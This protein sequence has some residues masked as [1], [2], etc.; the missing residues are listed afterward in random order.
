MFIKILI[1]V[2][3]TIF[4]SQKS[5]ALSIKLLRE[6]GCTSKNYRGCEVIFGM[7]IFFV[8]ILITSLALTMML[9][10]KQ[11]LNYIQ[12]LFAVF[13]IAFAGLLDDFI[14][15]KQIKGLRNHIRS[16]T[17]GKLTT[18]FIKAFMGIMASTIISLNLSKSIVD[19]IL[20]VLNIAL[21]TN[22]LNLMDLRPGRCI[23]IF[24]FLGT[25]ILAL[26]IGEIIKVLPLLIMLTASII[27]INYDLKEVCIIGDT[28]S[29]ILGITLGYFSTLT[30]GIVSKLMLFLGLII[31]NVLAEKLSITELISNN[32]ILSYLDNLGR[33]NS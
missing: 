20:N 33:S 14:G 11:Q 21:F 22:A 27:Y 30:I 29:N 10:H 28:G 4:I 17:K 12:Y 24:L 32:R 16:F 15:N 25:I 18:G 1:V 6:A 5:I 8:P 9:Y 23:K 19:F 7:G 13:V 3:F 2:L 31:V 26:N